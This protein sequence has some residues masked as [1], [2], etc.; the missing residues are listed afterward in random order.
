MSI[1]Q[2]HRQFNW[3]IMRYLTGVMRRD[4][5][6]FQRKYFAPGQYNAALLICTVNVF[7]A[8]KEYE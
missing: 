5:I 6:K 8:N 7:K 1:N 3:Q 4:L 2:N